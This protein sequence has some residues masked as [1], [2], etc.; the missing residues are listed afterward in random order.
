MP[1]LFAGWIPEEEYRKQRNISK[2]QAQ[3]ERANRTGP[4]YTKIGRDIYYRVEGVHRWMVARE[5]QP[6]KSRAV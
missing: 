6:V 2:R 5:I 3:R 4:P 1:D